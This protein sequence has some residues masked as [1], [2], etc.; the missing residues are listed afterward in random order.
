MALR[1]NCE[2]F[3]GNNGTFDS[4]RQSLCAVC[5]QSYFCEAYKFPIFL[6][7]YLNTDP[8]LSVI[9]YLSSLVFVS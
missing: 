9:R 2:R 5:I 3:F 7:E 8:L 1:S 6:V 4:I